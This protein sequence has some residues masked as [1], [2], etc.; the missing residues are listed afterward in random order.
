MPKASKAQKQRNLERHARNKANIAEYNSPE[1]RHQRDLARARRKADLDYDRK[2]E[3]LRKEITAKDELS[4][5]YAL[6]EC[7]CNPKEV[8]AILL[9][10]AERLAGEGLR[11]QA[12]EDLLNAYL[13]QHHFSGFQ[14]KKTVVWAAK[15]ATSRNWRHRR[16]RHLTKRIRRNS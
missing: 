2:M 5:L 6:A 16:T 13:D 3:K 8:R 7:A 15:K 11:R 14:R 9:A 4:G 12:I 1:V 10:E